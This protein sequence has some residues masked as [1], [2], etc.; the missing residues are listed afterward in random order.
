VIQADDRSIDDERRVDVVPCKRSLDLFTIGSQGLCLV[1][2]KPDVVLVLVRVKGDLLLL[3]AGW[4]HV[5]VRV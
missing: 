5:G 4:I 2:D 1:L 3:A